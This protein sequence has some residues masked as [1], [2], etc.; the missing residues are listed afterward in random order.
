MTRVTFPDG[1]HEDEDEWFAVAK[2]WDR[3]GRVAAMGDDAMGRL[4]SV[5][6]TLSD[7]QTTCGE[8]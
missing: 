2:S 1:T 5:I 7:K 4:R 6:P 3:L 8:F